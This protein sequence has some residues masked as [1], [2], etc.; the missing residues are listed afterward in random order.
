MQRYTIILIAVS[1]LHVSGSFS[2]WRL[3]YNV[4]SRWLYLKEHINDAR[5]HERQ[6][7]DRY[8]IK[9][10]SYGS[11]CKLHTV[12]RKRLLYGIPRLLRYVF[13]IVY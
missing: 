13:P 1:A 11:K 3:L 9:F 10:Y 5:Y 8:M 7:S 12:S 2:A 6:K 4:E